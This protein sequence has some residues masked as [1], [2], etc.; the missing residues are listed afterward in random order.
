[1][2]HKHMPGGPSINI[3][4]ANEHVPYIERQIRVIKERTG[5]VGH[6]LPFN[7]TPKLLTIYIIFTVIRII[8]YFP[9][10]RGFYAI[11]I[12]NTIISGETLN[13]KR[14]LG[15]NIGQ[16]CQVH[17]HEDPRNSQLP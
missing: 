14:Y 5:A 4:S 16:Y 11:L 15:L 6:S 2:V 7:K 3:T 8:N 10:K 13:Y 17:E 1:M 12:P 9:V